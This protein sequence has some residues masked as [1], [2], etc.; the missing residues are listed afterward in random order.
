MDPES[1][2]DYNE[3]LLQISTNLEN[4]L[5]T[6]GPSSRQYET[7]LEILKECLRNINNDNGR[8]SNALD[9]DTLSLAMGFLEIGK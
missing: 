8:K 1:G 2:V 7:V 4:A 5:N 6:F 3:I 9:P